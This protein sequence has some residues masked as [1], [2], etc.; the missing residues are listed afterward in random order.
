MR[1]VIR[2]AAMFGLARTN[3]LRT[4]L[5]SLGCWLLP[6]LALAEEAEAPSTHSWE[7]G[8]GPRGYLAIHAGLLGGLLS[9]D[10]DVTTPGTGGG[11][12]GYDFP[13]SRGFRLG[14]E[15]EFTQLDHAELESGPLAGARYQGALSPLSVVPWLLLYDGDSSELWFTP[16]LGFPAASASIRGEDGPAGAYDVTHLLRAGVGTT[17]VL[18]HDSPSGTG[19]GESRPRFGLIGALS[20]D[21]HWATLEAHLDD[22]TDE[23]RQLLLLELGARLGVVF[24]I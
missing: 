14:V 9:P 11:A 2:R 20:V 17:G 22:G 7:P 13:L 21:A 24:G 16:K 23:D 3:L 12:V 18:W 5:L 4:A 6:S 8:W 1:D 10:L 19:L 15:A